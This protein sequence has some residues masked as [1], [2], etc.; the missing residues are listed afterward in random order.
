MDRSATQQSN[1]LFYFLCSRTCC[2]PPVQRSYWPQNAINWLGNGNDMRNVTY[3]HTNFTRVALL[4][5]PYTVYKN[6]TITISM[7]DAIHKLAS[8]PCKGLFKHVIFAAISSAIFA[9]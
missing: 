9:F 5:I 4:S 7:S 8:F 6:S 2:D 3:A 1:V